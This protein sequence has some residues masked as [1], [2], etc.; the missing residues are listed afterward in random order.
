M[1][2][3][4]RYA[5]IGR[6]PRLSDEIADRLLE[7]VLERG[8]RP[9]DRLPT[10]RQL[11]EQFEVSRTVIREAVRTLVGRGVIDANRGSGLTVAEVPAST[12]QASMQL[13]LRNG[14]R[15][16]PYERVHEVRVAIEVEVAGHAAQRATNVGV[17]RLRDHHEEMATL[18]ER[19]E[20]ASLVD[21]AFHRELAR[22]TDNEL[23]LVVLDSIGDVLV[24][25]REVTWKRRELF[26]RAFVAHERILEAV[27]A[28]APAAASAAMRTHLVDGYALWVELEKAEPVVG[29]DDGR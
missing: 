27:A 5:P 13:F 11:G 25:V 28:R 15:E 29:R 22:L 21:V 8:A 18:L 10:E 16:I 6:R 12:V 24:D 1:K 20:N 4:A 17:A 2:P 7:D 3:S 19:G 14:Q 26:E 23:F 9:G